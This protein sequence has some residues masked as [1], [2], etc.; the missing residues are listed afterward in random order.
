MIMARFL[1]LNWSGGGNLPP[2]LGIA[3]VLEERGHTVTFAGRPEMVARV[4]Q[5]GLRAIE[6]TR[7]YEQAERYPKD[8][9]LWRM[10]CYLSSP[11]VEEQ[12]GDVISAESPDLLLVD[13]MFTAGLA[14][15]AK[16]PQPSIMMCHTLF[17]RH[18]DHYRAFCART[19]AS[20]QAAGFNPLPEAD[21][22][23]FERD[24]IITTSLEALDR[25]DPKPP[26]AAKVR[27]VGPAL[28]VERHAGSVDLPW[29]ADDGTPLV[30]L[31]F[32]TGPEQG[33]V[34]KM[35][36]T[37]DAFADLPAHVVAT[38]GRSIEIGR[39]TPPPNAIAL[40]AA[41]HDALMRRAAMVVTHGGHGTMMRALKHGLPMLVMPGMAADQAPNAALVEEIGAGRALNQDSSVEAIRAMAAH[42]LDTPTYAKR[43]R[44]LSKLI[45]GPDGAVAAATEIEALLQNRMAIVG[46]QH[47]VR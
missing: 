4:R 7:A 36:R 43:S 44:E 29:S 32:S 18:I 2:S 1:W 10:A 24:L 25:R 13:Q 40:D 6:L 22:L 41:D 12:V 14:R 11:A 26:E 31:S 28:E 9:P 16:A 8:W 3:R 20:R 23:W 30:V 17:L 42:M 37:L 33:N 34:D 15:A 47:A 21:R 5:A 38:G 45:A 27:H 46:V 35:Q 19:N 39:V